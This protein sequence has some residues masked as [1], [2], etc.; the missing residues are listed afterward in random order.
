MLQVTIARTA[1]RNSAHNCSLAQGI[2]V[3][4]FPSLST[5]Y[6]MCHVLRSCVSPH[7]WC[8]S[9]TWQLSNYPKFVVQ[10]VWE[11]NSASR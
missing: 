4:G 3:V 6:C 9:G 2:T 11:P 1:V 10:A 5:H 7:T 8:D